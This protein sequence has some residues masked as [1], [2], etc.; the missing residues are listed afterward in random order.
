MVFIW[1]WCVM[2]RQNPKHWKRAIIHVDM[3]AF[4]AFVEQRD[5]QDWRG[6]PVVVTNGSYGGT[7]ITSSYEARHFGIKTGMRLFEAQKLCAD[8]IHAP[9]RPHVY[10]KCS[11]Q[12]MRI[13]SDFT[14]EIEVFSVD[15]AFLDVTRVQKLWGSAYRCADLL[16]KR[17]FDETDLTCSVGLSADKTSAKLASKA[18]KPS[19]LTVIEPESVRDWLAPLPVNVLCGIGKG[20]AKYLR[21]NGVSNCGDVIK[22]PVSVLASRFGNPGRR[23]WLMCQGADPSK[24]DSSFVAAK[25][26]GHSKILPPNCAD[27]HAIRLVFSHLCEKLCA[28][29]RKHNY[30]SSKFWLGVKTK[31][32]G[33]VGEVVKPAA[34]SADT[35]WLLARAGEV[36]ANHSP[37]GVVLQLQVR[38]MNTNYSQQLDLTTQIDSREVDKLRDDINNRYGVRSIQSGSLLDLDDLTQV[39]SPSWGRGKD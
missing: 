38:A 10:A 19:G 32:W 12:I 25:S 1:G 27:E 2:G 9:S 17:I 16:Q 6:K 15:E 26:M 4:F 20:I 11:R 13:L 28:R 33:W 7:I 22:L 21:E 29:M 35:K 14:P 5:H 36:L 31:S 18:H 30:V 3:D 37:L 24:V 34:A 23:L 8:L 39:I